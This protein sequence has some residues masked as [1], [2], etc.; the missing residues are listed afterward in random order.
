MPT[1][2]CHSSQFELKQTYALTVSLGID[3]AT[4]RAGYG[5]KY[6]D[7]IDK[8]A[9]SQIKNYEQGQKK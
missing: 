1:K 6:D 8:V 3:Q 9:D 4:D 5:D 7:K 2:V